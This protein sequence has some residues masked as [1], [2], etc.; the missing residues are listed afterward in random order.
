MTSEKVEELLEIYYNY[1]QSTPIGRLTESLRN[2]D[3][4]INEEDVCE[5]KRTGE[6]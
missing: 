6:N 4:Q 1:E 5:K 2:L 3:R